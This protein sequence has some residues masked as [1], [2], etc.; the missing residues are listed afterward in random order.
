MRRRCLPPSKP[1]A[2]I[3]LPREFYLDT[4]DLVAR[5]LLG[6]LLVRPHE[7]QVGRIVE[8]EAYFGQSDPGGAFLF[9]AKRPGTRS[10]SVRPGMPTSI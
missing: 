8:V 9:P 7:G 1:M 10:S 4:P 2:R 6:K 5:K 3:V